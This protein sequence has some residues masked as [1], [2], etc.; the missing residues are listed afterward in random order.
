MATKMIL[1]S[2]P[3]FDSTILGIPSVAKVS[4]Q[5]AIALARIHL[6]GLEGLRT[7]RYKVKCSTINS[8]CRKGILDGRTGPTEFSKYLGRYFAQEGYI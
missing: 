2:I 1:I 8:L 7:D 5:E 3:L 6:G 4:K